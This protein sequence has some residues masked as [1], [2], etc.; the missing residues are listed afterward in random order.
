[1]AINPIFDNLDLS[2]GFLTLVCALFFGGEAFAG[3][4]FF[5]FGVILILFYFGKHL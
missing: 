2:S 4:F 5:M 1:M 3:L